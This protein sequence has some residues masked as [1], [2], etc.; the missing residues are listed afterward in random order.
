MKSAALITN[1]SERLTFLTSVLR[2][3]LQITVVSSFEILKLKA[4]SDEVELT[5]YIDR[6]AQPSD[7]VPID[8]LD[9][10]IPIIRS[11]VDS[12]FLHGWY[13]KEKINEE[14]LGKQLK[15]WVQYRNNRPGHGVVD[16]PTELEWCPKTTEL[17]KNCISIFENIIPVYKN[18]ELR[19]PKEYG[20]GYFH[21][22]LI[23]N[24]KAVVIRSIVPVKGIWKLKGQILCRDNAEAFTVDL[25]EDSAF[26]FENFK[27]IDSYKYCE[28]N[29]SDKDHSFYHNIPV[30]QT[31]TFEGR[32]P[33]L[34]KLTEWMDDEDSRHCLV[35]GDGGYGKTTTVLE[36]LNQYIEGG[37]DLNRPPPEIISYHT[38][39]MTKWTEQG[40]TR[41][42]TVSK[43]VDQFIRELMK[44][45]NEVLPSEWYKVSGRAL[46][47]KAVNKLKDEGYT[48]DEVLLVLD[49][50]ETLATKQ[51]EV[52]DLGNLFKD[53][54]KRLGRV[55]I[56]S[57]RRE[58]IE[59]RPI[60][61]EGLT[62]I[63]S[64]HLMQR[65]AIEYK[66][67]SINKA[68]E[69][70]LRKVSKKLMRKPLL[71][72][73]LV[74]Y[75]AHTG[76]GIQ[77][78]ID[79]IFK[80]SNEE[81]YDFLYEDA[82]LRMNEYQK[83]VFFVLINIDSPLNQNS[84]GS[85]C[86]R[87]GIQ[88]TEF[89][90]GL[91]ETHFST[92]VD[93]GRTYSLEFV[94]LANKFFLQEFGKL[95]EQHKKRIIVASTLVD[96]TETNRIRIESEY[97]EDRVAE[98]FRSEYAKSAKILVTKNEIPEAI[99]MY[100]L[101]LEDDPLNAAL[102]DRFA[103]LICNRTPKLDYAKTISEK[104]IALDPHSCAALVNL[105]I[106][107]YR[108][109]DIEQGDINIDLAR[110]EGR[111]FAFCKLRKAVGRYH[112][113]V[114]EV[115]LSIAISTLEAAKKLLMEAERYSNNENGY[116]CKTKIETDKYKKLVSS[117]LTILRTKRTK[118]L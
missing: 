22:P 35:F 28:V 41:L 77:P 43:T 26:S 38:A 87:V 85:A 19:Y 81:L 29:I 82:W 84:V 46:L 92:L 104:S 25:T 108:L 8:I 111:P 86:Q 50:T 73:A 10:L 33:E 62:E 113:A 72:D 112:Y 52:V 48:R 9:S 66:A 65:L 15:N 97:R 94:D 102:H 106:I 75:I 71:L 69:S 118:S 105:A 56:T 67:E 80:K 30:R 23:I 37:I 99:E 61:I 14:G 24:S 7:G 18:N 57:R 36:L 68:G 93:Y 101:A 78:A 40:L 116:N 21:T 115:D 45:F 70:T 31:D 89:Q 63:D 6:F 96:K 34:D 90:A 54:G 27:T 76:S 64:V 117:K 100:E 55:I 79:N 3:L 74:K 4:P 47:D 13:E 2:S 59:A 44:C 58:I 114:K 107:N 11:Y 95:N 17:L 42:N 32:L 39:K 83:D 16:I 53:I 98:A 12:Q 88:H 1:N 5:E 91:A 60:A 109:Q 20:N 110:K 49:N 51:N 103:W